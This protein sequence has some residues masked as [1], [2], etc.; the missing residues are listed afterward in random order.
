MPEM[1]AGSE[2]GF[3]TIQVKSVGVRWNHPAGFVVDRPSGIADYTF[4]QWLS[5]AILRIDGRECA[6]REGGCIFFR[7]GDPHWYGSDSYTPF[8]NNW[9]HF[10]GAGLDEFFAASEVPWNRPFHLRD[11]S[12]V[13]PALRS[14]LQ[15]MLGER[16]CWQWRVSGEAGL[17][18]VETARMLH[19]DRVRLKS[20]RNM[21]LEEKFADFRERLKARCAEPWTLGKMSGE[22]HLSPSR[23]S[24]LYRE[25]F[26]AKP[27]DD[28]IRMRVAL[29]EYYLRTTSIPISYVAGLCGFADIYYFS[30]VFKAKTGKTATAYRGDG[31]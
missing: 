6:E 30:R 18:L 17:F 16:L 8:I 25:F 10:N 12:F 27:V 13:E 11:D 21:E 24:N 2:N 22:L 15:E 9:F 14:F 5:P 1:R 28:L 26:D 23:F 20:A 31:Q 19:S 4:V 3:A 7:P 29:A